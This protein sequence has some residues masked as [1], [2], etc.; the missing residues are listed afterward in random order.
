MDWL[1]LILFLVLPAAA[2]VLVRAR[3]FG[4]AWTTPLVAVGLG[5]LNVIYIDRV[6]VSEQSRGFGS[7]AVMLLFLVIAL[8]SLV[9]C[10]AGH[11]TNWIVAKMRAERES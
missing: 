7:I 10:I 5:V 3:R 4:W 8:V 1:I 6:A 11:V 2:F 9:G